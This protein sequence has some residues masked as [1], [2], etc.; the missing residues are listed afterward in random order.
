M[1]STFLGLAFIRLAGTQIDPI[2]IVCYSC[3]AIFIMLYDL[4]SFF[5]VEFC[6]KRELVKDLKPKWIVKGILNERNGDRLTYL[7]VMFII[8]GPQVFPIYRISSEWI[9]RLSDF[10]TLFAIAGTI[11]LIA[12]KQMK[13]ERFNE[14]KQKDD[15][16]SVLKQ[17]IAL[18]QAEQVATKEEK[19]YD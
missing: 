19:V 9:G 14:I 7:A 12:F 16:I 6:K 10:S 11:M 17:Q 2:T 13:D 5:H 4:W 3:S 8:I 18:L 15:E 1:G